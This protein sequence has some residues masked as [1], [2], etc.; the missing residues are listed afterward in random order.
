MA[1]PGIDI[2]HSSTRYRVFDM[3]HHNFCDA[4]NG[5]SVHVYSAAVASRRIHLPSCI[6]SNEGIFLHVAQRSRYARPCRRS[7]I[8]NRKRI[9]ANDR[10]LNH[11]EMPKG[12]IAARSVAETSLCVLT[13]KAGMYRVAFADRLDIMTTMS[14]E[15]QINM[16]M[17][18]AR[19]SNCMR[20]PRSV[21]SRPAFGRSTLS[22]SRLILA[23]AVAFLS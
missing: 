1:G 4:Q 19:E 15:L 3:R 17:S 14:A 9:D 16:M 6:A 13:K 7:T 21:I 12:P 11:L 22:S 10:R 18:V 20:P 5:S 2:C 23:D 8:A